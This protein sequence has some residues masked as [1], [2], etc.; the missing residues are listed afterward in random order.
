MKTF[1]SLS[2]MAAFAALTFLSSCKKDSVNNDTTAVTDNAMAEGES[3][4]ILQAVNS[5][6]D[7]NDVRSD[8]GLDTILPPCAVVTID[9]SNASKSITIDFGSTPCLCSNW[10][11]K[12]R[13]GKITATWTG[14]YRDSGTVISIQTADYY[15]G[16][17]ASALNKFE[18]LKT[19]TNMG[20]NASGNLHFNINVITAIV[21]LPSGQLI[22]W[23][24]VRDRE[25]IAGEST[26]LPFDDK[27][28]ITGSASGTD[29]NGNPFTVTITN[30]VIVAFLCPWIEQGTLEITHGNFPTA[31]LDY[32]D[33]TCDDQATITIGNTTTTITLP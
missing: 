5:A 12:Y 9:T 13:E 28:S 8:E 17:N 6:A 7:D 1:A 3:N 30:P 20:H 10:D 18:Y 26:F 31:T 29:R 27:Y 19:V 32:G 2:L 22:I 25:W 11:N 16:Y 33:G 23:T 4:G 21:T 15:V 14:L 24:S